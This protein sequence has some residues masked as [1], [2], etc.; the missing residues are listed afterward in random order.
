MN[1]KWVRS[2]IVFDGGFCAIQG[3]LKNLAN[4]GIAIWYAIMG[5]A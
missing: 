3:A 1:T 5:S 2:G 4:V